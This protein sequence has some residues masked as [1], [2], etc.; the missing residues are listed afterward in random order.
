MVLRG[1]PDQSQEVETALEELRISD[2]LEPTTD[3]DWSY[4]NASLH[5]KMPDKPYICFYH[6]SK[7]RVPGA[8]WYMQPYN[9]ARP[10]CTTTARSAVPAPAKSPPS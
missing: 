5:P 1:T 10:I 2:H 4:V 9:S 7:T 3:Y 8:N 6:H